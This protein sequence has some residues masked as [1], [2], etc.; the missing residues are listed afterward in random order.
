MVQ[1]FSLRGVRP[2]PRYAARIAAPPYDVVSETETR[3][4]VQRNPCSF[5]QITRP[6]SLVDPASAC[7]PLE[8]AVA[9]FRRMR[10]SGWFLTESAPACYVYRLRMQGHV[11][12][13]W[14]VGASLDDYAAGVIRKHELTRADKENERAR[15][16]EA[17]GAQTGPV[18]MAY[19][20]HE[21]LRQLTARCVAAD[22]PVYDFVDEHRVEHA[23][24]V[25]TDPDALQTLCE[26]FQG[27]SALYIADGHHR[28]ASALRVRDILRARHGPQG[29]GDECNRLLA[30]VFPHDELRVLGYHRLVKDLN[31]LSEPDF[32]ARL[33]QRFTVEKSRR[34]LPDQPGELGMLLS[35]EWYRLSASPESIRDEDAVGRLDVSVLQKQALTPILGIG[36][37]RTDPRIDFV[38]G[39]DGLDRLEQSCAADARVAFAL[40]PV[41]IAQLMAVADAQQVMPPKSTWFEP[42]LRSGLVVHDLALA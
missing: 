2:D 42:K 37:V 21:G 35:G 20:A 38:G 27:G 24:W 29:A 7:D 32:L 3:E 9:A 34:F 13:G 5:L 12:T 25:V 17:L 33:A 26:Q 39:L 41:A 11:Q 8:R 6:E 40:P 10:A 16:I 31:G 14:I 30:A 18:L 19:R 23:L 15:H 22:D 1:V 36:D 28:A 4:R